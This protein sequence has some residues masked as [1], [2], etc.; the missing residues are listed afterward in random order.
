MEN[1]RPVVGWEGIYEVSDYG[2]TRR[3][4]GG[5]GTFVGRALDSCALRNG[6]LVVRFRYNGRTERPLLHSVVAEAFIGPRQRKW[7]V[8]H[9]NGIRTDNRAVN[10][11]Y[12]SS[13]GNKLHAYE[14]LKRPK[15]SCPGTKNGRAKLSDDQVRAIRL[16][17][18]LGGVTQQ[19]L[20]DEFGMSQPVVS[21]I[22][23]RAIWSLI[24]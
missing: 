3:V 20:A 23:R 10:L 9:L 16:R 17:Y 8:N 15:V 22:I 2:R 7:E 4:I 21:Q 11:E 13:S 5:K 14:T 6:Y 18:A 24:P 19:A 12:C 1:W